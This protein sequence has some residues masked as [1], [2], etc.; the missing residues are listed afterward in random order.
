MELYDNEFECW[1]E[2]HIHDDAMSLRLKHGKDPILAEAIVQIE[3]RNKARGKFD[4]AVPM[5][6]IGSNNFKLPEIRWYPAALSVEQATSASVAAFHASLVEKGSRV[7]DMTM[8]LGMDASMIALNDDAE[9]TAIE[10]N[11]RLCDIARLNYRNIGGLEIVNADSVEWLGNHG[12]CFDW[13]FIDP[14]RRDSAGKRV[15]NLHDCTPDVTELLPLMLDRAPNVLV[16]LS[17]MLDI[18]ATI[19]DLGH[20]ACLYVVEE[21]GECRE[22]L[23]HINRDVNLSVDDTPIRVVSANFDFCFTRRQEAMAEERHAQP[24]AG[25]CLC[26]PSAAMMKAAPFRL[27]SQRFDMAAIQANTHLYVGNKHNPDFPGKTYRIVEVL[28]YISKVIKRFSRSYPSASV[29]VRNF[30]VAAAALRSKLKVKDG[31][32]IKVYGVTDLNNAPVLISARR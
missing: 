7:L 22:L 27:L 15:Y 1:I 30:P 25:G 17:P 31:D 8:G 24:E 9:V 4:R 11:P 20:V 6:C 3:C 10:Q 32:D 26:E 21:R 29:A 12:E 18:A 14:A 19:A 28:P 23:V 13:I 16:K 5:A 2:S